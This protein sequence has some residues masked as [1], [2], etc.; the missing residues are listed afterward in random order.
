MSIS[1]RMSITG[2]CLSLPSNWSPRRSLMWAPSPDEIVSSRESRPLLRSSVWESRNTKSFSGLQRALLSR[3]LPWTEIER[4]IETLRLLRLLW[5]MP[6]RMMFLLELLSFHSRTLPFAMSYLSMTTAT[7]TSNQDERR[8]KLCHQKGM[9]GIASAYSLA[10]IWDV[11]VC[12]CP[13]ICTSFPNTNPLD[14]RW[15]WRQSPYHIWFDFRLLPS[16]KREIAA[17]NRALC[18]FRESFIRSAIRR[19]L[20]DGTSACLMERAIGKSLKSYRC[21][22]SPSHVLYICI[23]ASWYAVVLSFL[24]FF[25]L[26]STI[27][28]TSGH[29][30]ALAG[31]LTNLAMIF[32]LIWKIDILRIWHDLFETIY[33]RFL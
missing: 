12:T 24:P 9:E 5:P 15:F 6:L 19:I 16:T 17:T 13:E 1:R 29:M 14:Y 28:W 22:F 3:M 27:Y 7:E 18:I 8:R 23:L 11:Y 33:T 20:D 32:T 25:L 10:S 2:V 21:I 30:F 26:A 31:K 4:R